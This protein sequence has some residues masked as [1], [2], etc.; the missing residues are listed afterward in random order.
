M[1]VE[2]TNKVTALFA[3]ICVLTSYFTRGAYYVLIKK[4]LKNFTDARKREKIATCKSI[5]NNIVQSSFLIISSIITYFAGEKFAVTIIGGAFL[6][7]M[8]LQLDKMRS[9]VGKK[10]EEYPKSDI[11]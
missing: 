4:Y 1:F 10:M 6:I 3:V 5:A 2:P 9:T 8:V 7:I 11:L